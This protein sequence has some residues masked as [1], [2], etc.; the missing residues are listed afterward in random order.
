MPK[1]KPTAA[2]AQLHLQIYDL[3]R[4]ARMRQAREW[5]IQNYFPT[6]FEEAGRLTP[7]GSQE[8]AFTRMVISYWDQNCFLLNYGLLHEELFFQTSGEFFQVWDRV[9]PLMPVL[10]QQFRNPHMF[11][12]LEKEIGRAHV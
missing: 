3:R 12:N 10:R 1:G 9:K 6:S 7:P 2:Q 5:Y 11:S 4:E 8:N